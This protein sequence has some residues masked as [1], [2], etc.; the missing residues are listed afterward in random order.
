MDIRP[1]PIAGQWYSG[2][3]KQLAAEVDQFINQAFIPSL[4]GKVLAIV[5]PHAGYRYSGHVAGYGFAAIKDEKPEIVVV[6]SPMHHPY[7][8]SFLVTAHSAY[9]TPLGL[10]P[11]DR[12]LVDETSRLLVEQD[13]PPV[14]AITF[15]PEHSLEIELPFL[16]RVYTH[17]YRFLPIMV[18]SPFRAETKALGTALYQ[19][20]NDKSFILI[21]ST[22]LSHFY[23]QRV[24]EQLDHNMLQ[25]ITAL[26][27]DQ[28]FDLE[29]RDGGYACGLSGVAS[30][31][32]CCSLFGAKKAVLLKQATS[33]EVTGDF[34]SVVGYGSVAILAES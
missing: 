27:P 28:M 11:V 12:D 16:Q 5:V 8:E 18:K 9:S 3:P 23:P 24:A 4:P 2:N 13:F 10:M 17:P 6:I 20:L 22:D 14:K 31:I 19:V 32:D 25:A 29:K 30:V 1:S 15:D 33:G 7:R 21:A 34:N 26:S